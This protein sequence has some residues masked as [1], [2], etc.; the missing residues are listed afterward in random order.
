MTGKFLD[1]KLKIADCIMLTPQV[2]LDPVLQSSIIRAL[3]ELRLDPFTKFTSYLLNN[4]YIKSKISTTTLF[5]AVI[6]GSPQGGVLYCPSLLWNIALNDLLTN[7]N[8]L[9]FKI[10]AYAY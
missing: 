9:G 8:S 5:K 10:V 3:T 7:L 6:R 4:R 2:I 1:S